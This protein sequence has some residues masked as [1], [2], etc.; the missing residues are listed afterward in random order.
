MRP[1]QKVEENKPALE[2]NFT[3][4]YKWAGHNFDIE[5]LTEPYR[6]IRWM[7]IVIDGLA[8]LAQKADAIL[9]TRQHSTWPQNQIEEE[10]Q[11]I[12][13]WWRNTFT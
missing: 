4:K 7:H 2:L 1:N 8:G 13:C 5:Y 3:L 11:E 12:E 10:N 9:R 6:S